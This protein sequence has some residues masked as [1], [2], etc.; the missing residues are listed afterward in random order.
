[1]G[2]LLFWLIICVIIMGIAFSRNKNH[3]YRFGSGLFMSSEDNLDEKDDFVDKEY[4][5]KDGLYK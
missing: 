1:M 4:Y 2:W 3:S 5:D